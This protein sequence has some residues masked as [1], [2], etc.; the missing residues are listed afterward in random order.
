MLSREIA[1]STKVK[2]WTLT[3]PPSDPNDVGLVARTTT[4]TWMTHACMDDELFNQ[5]HQ[6]G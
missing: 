6:L 3:T 5:T 4:D 2:I 1:W